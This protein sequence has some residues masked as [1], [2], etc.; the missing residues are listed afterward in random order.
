M[1]CGIQAIHSAAVRC[2]ENKKKTLCAL[3]E[4]SKPKVTFK[5]C[6]KKIFKYKT[7][8]TYLNR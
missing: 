7:H 3:E 4:D 2:N 8:E 5:Q 1:L 6:K